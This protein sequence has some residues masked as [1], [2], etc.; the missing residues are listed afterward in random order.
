MLYLSDKKENFFDC[1]FLWRIN[2]E[3]HKLKK[4]KNNFTFAG[5]EVGR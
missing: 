2:I 1:I 4:F 3:N 5:N